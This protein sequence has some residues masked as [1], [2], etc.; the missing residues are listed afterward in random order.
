MT[1]ILIAE[2]SKAQR[3]LISSF[4]KKSN[5]SILTA[6]DGV[7]TL[8]KVFEYHPHIVLL[9]II[10]PYINGYDICR[11]IKAQPTTSNIKVIFCSSKDTQ[12]DR[13]WGLKQ[14]ADAYI[15]KPFS[16]ED[17]IYAINCLK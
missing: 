13:H 15:S 6:K 2:D 9:D 11:R 14:G 5:F 3:T 12:I 16:P 1:T 10:M 17:L 7:E 8:E 4:L